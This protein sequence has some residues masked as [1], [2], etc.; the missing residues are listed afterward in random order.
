ML[1]D[2]GMRVGELIHLTW[3]DVD[4][5]NGFIHIRPKDGWAPKTCD[6]RVIPMSERVAQI[7]KGLP[8]RQR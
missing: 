4:L 7:M 1:A 5:E 8:R 2:T 3:D 6:Q